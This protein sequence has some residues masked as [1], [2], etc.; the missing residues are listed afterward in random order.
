MEV[1]VHVGVR[2][3]AHELAVV[4]LLEG[5]GG[6]VLGGALVVEV[7]LGK[8][9]DLGA[10]DFAQVLQTGLLGGVTGLHSSC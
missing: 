9:V 10:L 8:A 4:L 5:L 3:G 7:H 6:V 1:P 2:E